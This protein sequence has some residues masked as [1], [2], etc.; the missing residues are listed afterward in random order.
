MFDFKNKVAVVTGGARG[1][2]KCICEE[3]E[4]AGAKVCII[5]KSEG[6]HYVGDISE[7][8]VL[9]LAMRRYNGKPLVNSVNGKQKVMDEVFPLIKK[10]GGTVVALAL[11]ES[12]IPETAEGRI[13]IAKKI[14]KEAEKYNIK[15]SDIIIDFLTLTCGTQQKEAKETLRGISLLKKDPEFADVKTV[16]GVSNISFG[17]SFLLKLLGEMPCIIRVNP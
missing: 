13:E 8:S 9:E 16:L 14:I 10:Y 12:G 15:K 6:D 4:K 3:F 1:I 5:D 2:G 7:K 17:S 11:D